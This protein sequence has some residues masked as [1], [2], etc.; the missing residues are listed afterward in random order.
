[1]PGA[2]EH[3]YYKAVPTFVNWDIKWDLRFS[4]RRLWRWLCSGKRWLQLFYFINCE[5]Q[6]MLNVY[7]SIRL[8]SLFDRTTEYRP[9]ILGNGLYTNRSFRSTSHF[10]GTTEYRPSL[11]RNAVCTNWSIWSI[12]LFDPYYSIS[13][14]DI[15]KCVCINLWAVW[16]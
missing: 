14:I 15:K 8:T 2:S 10:D 1:V 5:L 4:R 3:I 16:I 7:R 11:S 9:S 6:H 13:T 12:S